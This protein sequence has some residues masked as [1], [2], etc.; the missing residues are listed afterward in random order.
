M[1]GSTTSAI[2]YLM[3]HVTRLLDTSNYVRCILIDFAKAFDVINHDILLVKL[4]RLQLPDFVF[5][6]VS[7]F[8]S[9]R[10]QIVFY[11]GRSSDECQINQG[12]VQGS[13]LG[14]VLYAIM[15]SDMTTLSSMN[16]LCKYAD[17]TDLLVSEKTN[18]NIVD[19]F[20]NICKWAAE[21]R[22]S[23]NRA[24]TKEIIFHKPNPLNFVQPANVPG[25]EI[26]KVAKYLGF[27]LPNN[28]KFDEHVKY[29]LSQCSQ[30]IYL[31]KKLKNQGL[32]SKKLDIIFYALILSKIT[33]ALP[34]WGGYLSS[35]LRNQINA[36]LKRAYKCN[37]F[38]ELINIEELLDKCDKKLFRNISSSTHC[39]FSILP[40][41]NT[42]V[43]ALRR[44]GHDYSLTCIQSELCKKSFVNR[45][46][47]N[48]RF[49]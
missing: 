46:L 41:R 21:N 16:F 14:P 45:C 37:L 44:R 20:E 22:M 19:E 4:R 38:S 17:D 7:S 12:I 26:I 6:W 39:L 5:N 2:T 25:I 32:P 40:P 33:Y 43:Y 30:R 36:F 9:N 35:A 1:S 23:I 42:H 24:K 31:M 34:A 28:F 49:T 11:D 27:T 48:Y 18:T 3:H 8:L 29:T 13:G 15:A 47:F 10:S